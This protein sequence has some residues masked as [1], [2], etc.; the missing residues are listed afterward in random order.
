V[1]RCGRWRMT[2]RVLVPIEPVN[3]GPRRAWGW[4]GWSWVTGRDGVRARVWVKAHC[5]R[6]ARV[7]ARPAVRYNIR[8]DS[9]RGAA[10]VS[11]PDRIP[12]RRPMATPSNALHMEMALEEARA[13]H[14][15]GEVPV[16]AVIVHLQEGV[17]GRALQPAQSN[18]P[19]RPP[20]PRC[21]PSLRPPPPALLAPRGLHPLRHPRTLPH[22]RRRHRPGPPARRRLW[23]HRPQGRRRH[24]L[25]RITPGR[26][27][28]PRCLVRGGV[29]ADRA[30]GCLRRFFLDRRAEG[31]K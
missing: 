20:T 3:P 26:A 24:T 11:R 31:K 16:G 4:L 8:V 18:S 2:S 1:R 19:T 15:E 25:Y 12:A 13:A 5:S 21:S 30:A 22:V 28:Q 23:L 27:P 14:D 7:A 29:L 17:L 10:D 6:A 9:L